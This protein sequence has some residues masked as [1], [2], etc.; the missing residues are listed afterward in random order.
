MIFVGDFAVPPSLVLKW[1]LVFLS[2]KD[3]DVPFREDMYVKFH[4]D[5][6]HSAVGCEF[7]AN[8]YIKY[9][10]KGILNEKHT[11]NKVMY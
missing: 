2:A 9:N 5:M 4:S 6:S 11:L 3:C 1:C 7:N 8:E 10:L